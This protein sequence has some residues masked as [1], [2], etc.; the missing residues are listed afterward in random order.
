MQQE[1]L[2]P[3]INIYNNDKQS[4]EIYQK[5]LIDDKESDKRYQIRTNNEEKIIKYI[6]IR[7][8]QNLSSH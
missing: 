8:L 6:E 7:K 1:N 2:R 5:N 4:D 3:R